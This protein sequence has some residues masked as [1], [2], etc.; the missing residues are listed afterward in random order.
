MENCQQDRPHTGK[1]RVT[2]LAVNSSYSHS[3]LAAWCLR[4][5]VDE[6]K[7]AWHQVDATINDEPLAV[8]DRVRESRPDVVA[9]TLYVFNRAFVQE[10][11]G[12]LRT[13]APECLLV[14]GGPECLGDNRGLVPA[15]VD[16]AVRGEGERTFANMMASMATPS[17]WA[18]IPG[19][20]MM[21]D[22]V[23]R[24]NGM[25]LGV[26]ELDVIPNFYPAMLDGFMR[27]FVQLE[28]SRGCPN[29]CL[30]CTSRQTRVRY[31]SLARIRVELAA[32]RSAGVRTVRV[33][34]RTF[35]L[36]NQRCLEL[37]RL[38][39]AE[40]SE[41]RF[42][43]EI[44]P[45]LVSGDAAA[46]FRLAPAGSLHLEVGVQSLESRVH[47]I[48]QRRASPEQTLQGVQ[49]LADMTNIELHADLMA[50]LPGQTMAGLVEDAAVLMHTRAAEIQLER[51]KLL[52]GTP[53]AEAPSQ[54]GLIAS[55][56]P[57]YAVLQTPD[58]STADL[59]QA[60]QLSRV[61]D[62]F[63]NKPI[64][65]EV[66]ACGAEK[67]SGYL[68]AFVDHCAE[69]TGSMK[70]PSLD[71]RLRLLESFWTGRSDTMVQRVRYLWFRYGLSIRHGLCPA[72]PWKGALPETA[73]LVEG[74]AKAIYSRIWRVELDVPH[75]FCFGTG[76]NG[77]R[78][79]LA[80]FKNR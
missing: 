22:G 59:R 19:V 27:P 60:D 2:F 62:W 14:A 45:G 34:D 58:M 49:C 29:G 53:L 42:H 74:D 70:C 63:Y 78:A 50:G 20:C 4:V 72:A 36:V 57:P 38:F 13:L 8:L 37:L 56:T 61:L 7:V 66:F 11:L 15:V 54:W 69:A 30:F 10:V 5:M 64:L 6:N 32:I 44:D 25:A 43:L 16:V 67:C 75:F 76:A 55:A 17:R 51:L 41:I 26:D 21:A 33:V 46:E 35:N 28:T 1:T 40:Y 48:I 52:P 68:T 79:V 80:V 39:R 71:A 73:V 65:R 9:T 47:S 31:K 23:Y 77:E 18:D 12:Q 3:S 24:D